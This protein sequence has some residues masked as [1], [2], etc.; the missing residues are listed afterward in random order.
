MSSTSDIQRLAPRNA[1]VCAKCKH[2]VFFRAVSSR[3]H[4]DG[5]FRTVYLRCPECGARA[6]RLVETIPPPD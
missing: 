5:R 4:A 1:E 3:I 6:S 2:K